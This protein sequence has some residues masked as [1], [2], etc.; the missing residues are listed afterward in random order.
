MFVR[1]VNQH[2]TAGEEGFSTRFT[3]PAKPPTLARG[4]VVCRSEPIGIDWN[5]G[6][7]LIVKVWT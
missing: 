7:S 6:L 4:R 2:D 3:V 1:V 5:V